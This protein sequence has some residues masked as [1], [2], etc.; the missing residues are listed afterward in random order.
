MG[1]THLSIKKLVPLRFKVIGDTIDR[2]WKSNSSYQQHCQNHVGENCCHIYHLW[3][4][5]T[6]IFLVSLNPIITAVVYTKFQNNALWLG[7][8]NF[9]LTFHFYDTNSLNYSATIA[10]ININENGTFPD[11]LIP[12]INGIKVNVQAPNRAN[13]NSQFNPPSSCM[14]PV[15]CNT[16]LL[17]IHK[18]VL[19]S[20]EKKPCV[21]LEF[22]LGN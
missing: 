18:F 3:V 14:P 16:L 17:Q 12:L 8:Y 1:I 22:F 2:I 9:G 21:V 6:I 13:T 4:I 11:D 20:L 5:K 19:S 15:M 10:F 7:F